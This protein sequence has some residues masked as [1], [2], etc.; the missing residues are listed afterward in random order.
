MRRLGPPRIRIETSNLP[1]S[2]TIPLLN[3]LHWI[4]GLRWPLSLL[5]QDA[6]GMLGSRHRLVVCKHRSRSRMVLRTE[7]G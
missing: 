1:C 2:G 4:V 6:H 7:K 5:V 3:L